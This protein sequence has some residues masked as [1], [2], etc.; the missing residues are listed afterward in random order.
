MSHA[1]NLIDFCYCKD[2][3]AVERDTMPRDFSALFALCPRG[4]MSRCLCH[5]NKVVRFPFDPTTLFSVC[6]PKRVSGKTNI[7]AYSILQAI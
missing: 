6:R 7:P 1:M 5:D 2:T 4:K 3:P